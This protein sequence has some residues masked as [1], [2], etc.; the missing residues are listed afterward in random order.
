MDMSIREFI[1]NYESGKYDDSSKE[2]MI[3]A[4]WFDWFCDDDELKPRLDAMF[5]KVKQIAQ[6]TKIDMDNMFVFFKNSRPLAG[7]IYDDFR[8]C[9][10]NSGDVVYTVIPVSGQKRNKGQAEL[11][12]RENYFDEAL[13][14]G[15][16]NNIVDF[17]F[18]ED[19]AEYNSTGSNE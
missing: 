8:F 18:A 19:G 3:D 5:P 7:D 9:E 16:W 12:G 6:S 4:G 15:A 11:W 14:K 13:T 1:S 2:T 17:F 10:I